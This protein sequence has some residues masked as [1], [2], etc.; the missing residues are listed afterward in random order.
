MNKLKRM[1]NRLTGRVVEQETN[2]RRILN[3]Q[4]VRLRNMHQS[5]LFFTIHKAASTYVSQTL[6][7]ILTAARY[8]H[9]DLAT[10]SFRHMEKKLEMRD[11]YFHP[12]GLYYGALR[13]PVQISAAKRFKTIVQ[14][15]DPRDVITSF[16]FSFVYSHRAPD[17]PERRKQF[18]A[19]RRE[20][21]ERGIDA[22]AMNLETPT[23]RTLTNY[24]ENF[25]TRPDVLVVHYEDMVCNFPS[26]IDRIMNY[27]DLPQ[28]RRL[29]KAIAAVKEIAS[30]DVEK[31]DVFSHK[32]Q[33]TPGDHLRKL[34]PETIQKLNQAFAPYFQAMAETNNFPKAYSLPDLGAHISSRVA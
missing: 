24:A 2:E 10:Y 25:F 17:H 13:E 11:E 34:Q 30:F 6:R 18:E 15:R 9:I 33:V 22:Y 16:Y 23:L 3:A 20:L 12:F 1:L 7:D 19:R 14:V 21:A 28:T 27:I 31:E 4:K 26:W 8:Q 5:V 32:R 29:D